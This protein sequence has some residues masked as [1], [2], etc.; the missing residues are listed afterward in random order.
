[1]NRVK[2]ILT[3]IVTLGLT[4][5]VALG[6]DMAEKRV[7]DHKGDPSPTA[8]ESKINDYTQ[9]DEQVN[10]SPDDQDILVLRANQKVLL[11]RYVTKTFPIR[12]VSI[13][14]LRG[15][16]RE[17]CGKEGGYAD[18]IRDKEKNEYYLQ[19][20]VPK[21][22]LPF[23]EQVIPILDQSWLKE[24]L[25][26]SIRLYYKAKH[27]FI[28]DFHPIL[29]DWAGGDARR[30]EIDENNNALVHVNEPYRVENYQKYAK[31]VDIPEHQ[32]RFRIKVYEINVSN[33]LRLGLD[34][35]AWKNGP[36]RNLF[37]FGFAGYDARD[38]FE[39][40]TGFLTPWG[41]REIDADGNIH[42]RHFVNATRFA[43]VNYLLTAAYVDFL[44]SKGKAKT[45]A[46]GVVQ[47]KSGSVGTLGAL[48]KVVTFK[49]LPIDPGA[50][51]TKPTRIKE[52]DKEAQTGDL[53]VFNRFLKREV[54]GEVG[55]FIEIAP[56]I[57][58]ETMEV[59][60]F[61]ELSDVEG[62]TPQGLPIITACSAETKARLAD[63]SVLVLAG[64]TRHE[65]V[66]S[67]QGVPFLSSL[68]VLGYL[69]GGEN[70]INRK[71]QIVIVIEV[72]GETGGEA[73]LAN[74]PE[75]KTIAEQ[76]VGEA[77]PELPRNCF[78]FDMWLLGAKSGAQL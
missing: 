41:P 3:I 8:A 27:R 62:Y 55:L 69:F 43:Y 45:L 70:N 31:E 73:K 56:V 51:G 42:H 64:L 9:Q 38:R 19:V 6:V 20:I 59:N 29:D 18:I 76:V 66:E 40:V 75:I 35:I 57:L 49:A 46:E 78:G 37:E 22:Q 72:E 28:G 68:P 17:L 34:Y 12:N 5:G 7:Q 36:G 65:K 1:M 15:P 74:P 23:I 67:K 2:A 61:A 16:I 25:D 52:I 13:R 60:V 32:A 33:D 11:N 54:T 26:G 21:W 14:E 53:A 48:E 30:S 39:N 4:T 10:I 71:T 63:G 50:T 77:I 58:L 44:A 24:N 47:V